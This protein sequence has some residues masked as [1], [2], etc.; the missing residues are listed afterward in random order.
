M[1]SLERLSTVLKASLGL[2]H[3]LV[4][5]VRQGA[6]AGVGGAEAVVVGGDVMEEVVGAIVR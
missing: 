5:P 2:A 1:K 4:T 3:M 6:K